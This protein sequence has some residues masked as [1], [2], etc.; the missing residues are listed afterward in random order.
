MDVFEQ[1]LRTDNECCS[2]RTCPSFVSARSCESLVAMLCSVVV[3]PGLNQCPLIES[4]IASKDTHIYMYVGHRPTWT[5]I[6]TSE[7]GYGGIIPPF[8]N[9]KTKTSAVSAS[10]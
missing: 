10:L 7:V 6:L 8:Q 2:C 1:S 5:C 3:N 9:V 4:A